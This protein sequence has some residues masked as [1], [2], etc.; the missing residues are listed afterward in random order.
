MIFETDPDQI[1]RLNSLQLVL[2]MKRLLLAECRLADIPLRAGTVPLQITV[3]DGGED[4]RIEW[5]GGAD[6]TDYFP[7]RF[8]AFQAKAQNLTDTR[9]T[10]EVLKTP[11]NG[12]VELNAAVSEV[13]SRRGAYIVFCSQPFTGQKI[14]KLRKAIE[15]AIR[16]GG[17]DPSDA[18]AIEVYDA[19][20][21]AE[22]ANNHPPVALWLTALHRRR[23]LAGFSSHEAWGRAPDIST[24][25][26]VHSETRRFAPITT[27]VAGAENM[28][29]NRD[30]W[31]F[32]EAAEAALGFLAKDKTALRITGPSG[33]G[34]S[35]F[36][37]EIFNRRITVSDEIDSASLIY[38]D[39]TVVADE[40]PKLA[41]EIADAGLPAILVVDECPDDV[42]LKLAEIARRA[43][44]RL[45]L[46]TIDVET[47]VLEATNTLV[48]RLEPAVDELIGAIARSVSPALQDSDTRFIQDLARGFP[49]MAVLAAQQNGSGRRA[50]RSAEQVLDRVIWGRRPHNEDAQR[51]LE[52]L[53]LFEWVG[54]TGRVGNESALIA[55]KLAGMTHDEFVERIKSFCSRGIVVQRGDFVQV[56]PIPLAASLG[57]NRLSLLPGGRLAAF[58]TYAPDH[59]RGSLLRRFRWLDKSAEAKAFA[60][61]LLS[62][63]C[64]GNLATLNTDFGAECLDR[65]THVDPEVAMATIERE[66]SGLTNE[67]L[68]HIEAGRR[69]LV[70]ALEKLAFRKESF[71]GAAT[72][73]RRLAASENEDHISN[74]ATGQFKQLYQLYLSG[75]EVPPGPRLLVLDDGLRSK[76]QRERDVCVEA[77]DKMLDTHYFSRGGGAEEIGSRERLEDWRPKTY[78]EIGDFLR[79]GIVRLRDMAIGNDPLAAKAKRILGTHIRG[80]ISN[81]PL[82]EIKKIISSV[83]SRYGFW[84]EA[85]QEVNEWLYFDRRNA[86][87]ILGNAVRIYFDELM[88]SD[89]VE[90]V[91]VYTHGWPTDFHNPDIDYDQ[92]ERIRIDFEYATRRAVELAD[93]I[94]ADPLAVDRVRDRLVTSESK[95][96]FAFARRLAEGSSNATELFRKALRKAEDS[97]EEANHQF[98]AGLVAG[99]DEHDPGAARDCIRL[100]LRSGK[101]K[102]DAISLIRAGKLQP[103]D[104]KLVMSLLQ[105]NDVEP[106]QCASL[107]YGRGLDHLPTDIV[108]SLLEELALHGAE[109][110]WTV[111]QIVTMVLHG[112][113]K[114]PESFAAILRNVLVAPALF[115]KPVQGSTDGYHFSEM[116]KLLARH[117]LIDRKFAKALI[118]Q[119]LSICSESSTSDVFFGLH[120]YIREALKTLIDGH[121]KEVWTA[122]SRLLIRNGSLRYR[123]EDLI[124]V[125]HDDHL[126]PGL[127]YALPADL[128]LD[129][130]RKNAKARAHLVLEWLPIALKAE[131]RNYP[132]IQH[133]RTSSRSLET[134]PMCSHHYL[135]GFIRRRGSVHWFLT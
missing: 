103:N 111:M 88:P 101:L 29:R 44:S 116:V 120:G 7:A 104:I 28:H 129:W 131:D 35:R 117:N 50:M 95:S 94:V 82:D 93:V 87:E 77:L 49:K 42:H 121:P 126:G 118:S 6:A 71:D 19:N 21:I 59:L 124:G 105:S 74:N 47:K 76:D 134:R 10:A 106:R 61:T 30:V 65:L 79:A 57:A 31:T 83:M 14:K 37:F 36:V 130:V 33:F 11:K 108:V 16:K 127:L 48:L 96:V 13:L 115:E 17:G 1:T 9:V 24:V 86:P 56:T 119:L 100:A 62:N 97:Q 109:G 102:K 78:G 107:S 85:V 26:W 91:A 34:K 39:L 67:E 38:A 123:L 69:H 4:G 89:P 22:W 125:E 25:P 52:I 58:F 54:L 64:L 72:L 128:Y 53:S 132:G 73:L 110:L 55:E 2:L 81:L 5:T 60:R 12:P 41:L 112:G 45:R 80:L 63:E 46:V 133:L 43:G 99:A 92:E 18:A 70:W 75:T 40:V 3:A 122:I 135:A 90:L 114:T 66:F 8:C 51:A 98:F 15:S 27:I 23:S 32:E 113:K 68:Q 20:R 84:Y